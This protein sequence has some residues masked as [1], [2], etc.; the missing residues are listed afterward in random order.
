MISPAEFIPLGEEIGLIVPIGEWVLGEACR[1]NRSWQNAGHRP[2]PIAVNVSAIQLERDDLVGKVKQVL[3]QTG[4]TPRYLEI[5][6][7]ES[8]LMNDANQSINTL[9]QLRALGVRSAV[10]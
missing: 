6:I 10:D 4:L 2:I 3:E 5:E 1:V 8:G 9:E 7:T